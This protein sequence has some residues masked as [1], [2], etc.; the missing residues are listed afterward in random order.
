MSKKKSHQE[1]LDDFDNVSLYNYPKSSST[2]E[3]KRIKDYDFK[4]PKKFTKEHLRSLNTVNENI[5]RIFSSN[6]SSMLRAFCEIELSK[7]EE[8]RYVEY[9]NSLPDKTFVGLMTMKIDD[10]SIDDST[11]IIHFP[12]QINFLLIDIL[13]GG[14]GHGYDLDRGYTEIEI[15]ILENFY[16]KMTEYFSEAWSSLMNVECEMYANETNP[17][18]AQFISLEDSVI[19]LSFQIKIRD[20]VEKFTFCI[21]SINVDEMLR[22]NLSKFAKNSNKMEEEKEI[23]RREA[24]SKSLNDSTLELTAVLD[25]VM[26]DVENIINLEVSDVIP[27]RRGIDDNIILTVEGEPRFTVRLGDRK[28]KKSVKICDVVKQSDIN[29]FNN[30]KY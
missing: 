15:A 5:I 30:I 12:P 24:L 26:L 20:V 8:L 28:I 2:V 29:E 1:T 22:T 17:R 3:Q 18:L 4:K 6:I 16:I 7:M 19:V 10:T 21:P 27:L 13:L 14:D 23:N 9:L 25:T 11:A